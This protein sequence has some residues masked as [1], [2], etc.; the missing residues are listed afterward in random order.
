MLKLFQRLFVLVFLCGVIPAAQAQLGWFTKEQRI[1]FTRA[2]KGERFPDGRPR[3][4]DELLERMRKAKCEI[5]WGVMKEAGYKS[6]IEGGWRIIN[7]NDRLVGRVVTA[8]FMSVRP[9]MNEVINEHAKQEGRVGMGQNSWVIDTLQPNDVLV[10]DMAGKIEDGT[11]S[12]DNLATSIYS[13]TKTGFVVNG[14]VRD[15]GGISEIKGIRVY[16]RDFHPSAIADMMLMGINVPIRIGSVTVMPG[17]VILSDLEG[18]TFVPPH[19]AEKVAD[20]SDMARLTDEWGHEMLRTG[21][22]SP[23]E[24][25]AKWSKKMVEEFNKYADSQGSKVRKKY[26]D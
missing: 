17:D 8:V 20:E 24:V 3:V 10:V 7:P 2:W 1:D 6:Q 22:Y 18:L 5:A 12:G 16:V 21:K 23:G 19:M 25:D 13:K 9:D 4:S 26:E 11:F 14:G 15:A